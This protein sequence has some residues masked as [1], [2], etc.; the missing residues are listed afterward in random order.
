MMLQLKKLGLHGVLV[1]ACVAA[2]PACGGESDGGDHDNGVDEGAAE[3]P[4]GAEC[5]PS[6]PPTYENFGQDFMEQYCTRCPSSDVPEAQRNGAPDDHNF[7]S[8]AEILLMAEHIDQ[9][10]GAGPTN[11]NTAMPPS[12]PK[13][14]MEERQ[15]LAQWLACQGE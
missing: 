2:T 8:E 3:T 7:D 14:S 9:A 12:D 13:P 10:A 11:I 4:S 15:Q 1:V 6:D 5:P